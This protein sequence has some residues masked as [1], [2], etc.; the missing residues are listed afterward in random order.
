VPNL[1]R[2]GVQVTVAM[3][4]AGCETRKA[5]DRCDPVSGVALG[6]GARRLAERVSGTQ[7]A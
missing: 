2:A 4:P 5:F 7:S 6:E 1:T 3:A